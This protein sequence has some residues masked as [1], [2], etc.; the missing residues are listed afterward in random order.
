MSFDK[1][2][3]KIKIVLKKRLFLESVLESYRK[4]EKKDCSSLPGPA[5]CSSLVSRHPQGP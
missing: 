5:K 2:S 3:F 1:L 4:E